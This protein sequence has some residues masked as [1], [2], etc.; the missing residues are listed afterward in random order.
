MSHT[1]QYTVYILACADDSYYTG[2]TSDVPKRMYEHETGCYVK[3]YTYTRRPVHLVYTAVFVD[4]YDA[5][6]WERRLK[7]WSHVKKKALITGQIQQLIT[8]AKRRTNI[9]S[10]SDTVRKVRKKIK[11]MLGGVWFVMVA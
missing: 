8:Y 9:T 3:C 6:A 4:V 5:I 2:L 1:K 11:K 10:V 7:K